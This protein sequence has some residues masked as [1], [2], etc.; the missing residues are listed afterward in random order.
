MRAKLNLF[1]V[2]IFYPGGLASCHSLA[3]SNFVKATFRKF[4]AVA[5]RENMAKESMEQARR[6][7]ETIDKK[8][9]NMKQVTN[10][11]NTQ[12]N[13]NIEEK[14]PVKDVK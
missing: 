7:L 14:K 11:N 13:E 8:E 1:R 12:K 10:P 9:E 2:C 4:S 3:K 5:A 6:I